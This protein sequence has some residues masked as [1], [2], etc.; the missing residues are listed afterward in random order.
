MQNVNKMM[1]KLDIELFARHQVIL[2]HVRSRLNDEQQKE[3]CI[4]IYEEMGSFESETKQ[5]GTVEQQKPCSAKKDLIS[6]ITNCE[7][8]ETSIVI[9]F[10]FLNY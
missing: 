8:K 9:T 5:N 7:V 2:Q 10:V 1:L 4:D 3:D 6:K